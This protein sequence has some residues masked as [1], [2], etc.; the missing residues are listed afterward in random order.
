MRVIVSYH[1][2]GLTINYEDL[3][4]IVDNPEFIFLVGEPIKII[5]NGVFMAE[6]NHIKIYKNSLLISDEV[7]LDTKVEEV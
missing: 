3:I 5:V 7:Y 2:G 4:S 1:G 6:S